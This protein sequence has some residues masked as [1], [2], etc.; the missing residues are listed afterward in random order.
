MKTKEIILE[1]AQKQEKL[2]TKDIA[3]KLGFSHQF[4]S[5]LLRELVQA[6][7]LVKFGSTR[8]AFYTLP[9]KAKQFS[10]NWSQKF[11]LKGLQ[12]H[13]VIKTLDRQSG[14]LSDL[15]DDVRSIFDYAFSEMLNNAIEHSRSTHAVISVTKG[16]GVLGFEIRDFGIGVFRNVMQERKLESELE[17]IQDLLKGKTT[18]QPHAHSGEG[19]YFT[20]KIADVFVLDS[21]GQQLEVNNLLL[22]V[23][24]RSDRSRKGTEV[25]FQISLKSKKHLGDLFRDF[26]SD[27]DIDAFDKT[28]ILVRLYTSGVTHVSRSQ[29]RRILTGLEKFKVVVL[30]FD[31]VPSIGQAFA[32]EIF[33]VWENNH[34][35]INIQVINTNKDV[36]FMIKRAQTTQ[37]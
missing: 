2:I 7:E 16:N 21:F 19:I 6:G 3:K 12:E 37:R 25:V 34:P 32:D 5:L 36:G 22:D 27:P 26:K 11:V 20:S 15:T 23:F 4:A 10:A 13:E 18:T 35:Q 9:Q 30:D 31:H 29:A 24:V 8:S 14:L 28:K 33:R 17:A 1:L